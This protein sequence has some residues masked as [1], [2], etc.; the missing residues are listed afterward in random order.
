MW[1]LSQA[2]FSRD[3]RRRQ[4]SG[5]FQ[6]CPATTD[7]LLAIHTCCLV[8]HDFAPVLRLVNA[9][10]PVTQSDA[11]HAVA[12]VGIDGGVLVERVTAVFHLHHAEVGI[13]TVC[14]LV[15]RQE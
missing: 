9:S 6:K 13:K 5:S 3:D 10:E 8:A 1:L 11:V 2:T 14:E 12:R 7:A 15:V 4:G